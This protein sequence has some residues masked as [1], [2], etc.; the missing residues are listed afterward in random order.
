MIDKTIFEEYL[1]ELNRK[2][3]KGIPLSFI[4]KGKNDP[5]IN[6]YNSQIV[7]ESIGEEVKIA[8]DVLIDLLKEKEIVTQIREKPA[9][10]EHPEMLK[11]YENEKLKVIAKINLFDQLEYSSIKISMFFKEEKQLLPISEKF[12]GYASGLTIDLSVF[13]MDNQFRKSFNIAILTKSH[14]NIFK[15]E[16]LKGNDTE[17]SLLSNNMPEIESIFNEKLP[18]LNSN[19]L[20]LY[21]KKA[22]GMNIDEIG[23]KTK[24]KLLNKKYLLNEKSNLEQKYN[25]NINYSNYEDF[26]ELLRLKEDNTL[27]SNELIKF[28]KLV[29]EEQSEINKKQ[30]LKIKV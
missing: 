22:F 24:F 3:Y 23:Q 4:E 30:I 12:L 14:Y 10:D 16:P 7:V 5:L 28:Y 2:Q 11:E 20:I 29:K 19:L 9:H 8:F 27:D 21:C 6:K 15:D 26:L 1:I 17:Y 13:K 18:D 25:E